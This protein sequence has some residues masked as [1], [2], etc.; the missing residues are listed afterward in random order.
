MSNNPKKTPPV[1]GMRLTEDE[2]KT[3]KSVGNGQITQGARRLITMFNENEISSTNEVTTTN[4]KKD[5]GRVKGRRKETATLNKPDL[6]HEYPGNEALLNFFTDTKEGNLVQQYVTLATDLFNRIL[7]GEDVCEDMLD[8]LPFS[9]YSTLKCLT[10]DPDFVILHVAEEINITVANLDKV[11][12]NRETY[13]S[14]L[15][16]YPDKIDLAV[17]DTLK[18]VT[19][20]V[21]NNIFWI[22][23]Q[24]YDKISYAI[25]LLVQLV[26]SGGDLIKKVFGLLVDA[27]MK[28]AK[29]STGMR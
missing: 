20:F 28:V 6:T 19:A 1:S 23:T 11:F 18:E 26:P 12:G 5:N 27:E 29:Q 9:V 8:V 17:R 21:F 24:P 14:M 15:G 16:K 4:N 10:I 13:Q 22:L 2:L 7:L 25:S 3:L